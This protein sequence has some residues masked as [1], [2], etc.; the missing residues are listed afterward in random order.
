[1]WKGPQR[2]GES[3]DLQI[4]GTKAAPTTLMR[5]VAHRNGDVLDQPFR[6]SLRRRELESHR[7]RRII[8]MRGE[9][10]VRIRRYK[11]EKRGVEA[12]IVFDLDR[13]SRRT[14][15]GETLNHIIALRRRHLE[16][17]LRRKIVI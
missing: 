17:G 12:H 7:L 15:L 1:M 6:C 16:F 10:A 11:S 5:L 8:Q 9:N 4:R 13:L 3:K 2:P 14:E